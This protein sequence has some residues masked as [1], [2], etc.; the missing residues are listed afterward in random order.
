MLTLAGPLKQHRYA[1]ILH[2]GNLLLVKTHPSICK[3]YDLFSDGLDGPKGLYG[4]MH[5]CESSAGIPTTASS[6]QS[7]EIPT[8]ER[9]PKQEVW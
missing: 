9:K 7:K 8:F 5:L 3:P 6:H 1:D 2:S 4:G